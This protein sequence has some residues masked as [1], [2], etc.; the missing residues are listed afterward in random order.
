MWNTKYVSIDNF[1]EPKHFDFLSKV[2]FGEVKPKDR[3]TYINSVKDGKPVAVS[4]QIPEEMLTE[5][6]RTY[7]PKLLEIL[8]EL[9]PGL[10]KTYTYTELT[11]IASGKDYSFSVH[12]DVKSKILSVVVYLT[13]ENNKGTLLYNSK[14]DGQTGIN[15]IETE[16]KQ[17]RAFIFSRTDDSWHNYKGDGKST[18]TV[19]VYNLRSD[20]A[21]KNH[22]KSK[23]DYTG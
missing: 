23:K 20:D 11:V 17:N 13:P 7:T 4:G 10:S 1:L 9:A 6:D 5:I 16:W 21:F 14:K 19:L 3:K 8:E 12:P 18:R 2:Q 22:E 15:E